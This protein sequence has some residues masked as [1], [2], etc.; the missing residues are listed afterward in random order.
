MRL[1]LITSLVHAKFS[2]PALFSAALNRTSYLSILAYS[3]KVPE[4]E[5]LRVADQGSQ[6]Q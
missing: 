4:G 3:Y 6:R 2:E 1:R 5:G